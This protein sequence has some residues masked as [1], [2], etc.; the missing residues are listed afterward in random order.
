MEVQR[1]VA[2]S[3]AAVVSNVA[4]VSSSNNA[5]RMAPTPSSSAAGLVVCSRGACKNPDLLPRIASRTDEAAA[6]QHTPTVGA[7]VAT[8]AVGLRSVRHWRITTLGPRNKPPL[9]VLL[10]ISTSSS[11]SSRAIRLDS[12]S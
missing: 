5:S 3:E 4:A 12:R 7:V 11:S 1:V 8:V 2:A 9:G 6:V 10:H